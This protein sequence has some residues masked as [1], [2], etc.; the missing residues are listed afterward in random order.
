MLG[1]LIGDIAGTFYGL[2]PSD[3][4]KFPLFNQHC[5]LTDDSVMTYAIAEALL[6]GA[7]PGD[8]VRAI[9]KYKK[10]YS[11]EE[12]MVITDWGNGV[13]TRVS[14]CAWFADS[15]EEAEELAGR[16]ALST[17]K[18]PDDIRGAK[19][20][21]AAIYLARTGETKAEIRNL[22][23]SRYIYYLNCSLND[24]RPG[25]PMKVSDRDPVEEALIAFLESKSFEGAIRNA[26]SLGGRMDKI[27][28][29]TGSLAEAAYGI[30]A[31]LT[32]RAYDFIDDDLEK[33]IRRWAAFG[34]PLS[35]GAKMS[36]YAGF[37]SQKQF[38][39]KI[40][41]SLSDTKYKGDAYTGYIF[42][43]V[44]LEAIYGILG[45]IFD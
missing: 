9:E 3:L 5:Y 31:H 30:P 1:A 6:N 18:H 14:P 26:I 22:I 27:G 21:S 4:K 29:I 11:D 42:I 37:E 44:L 41:T 17:H 28:A 32:E 8:F 10:L 19:A 2:G 20:I 16:S 7:E 45:A 15:L 12:G 36:D 43:D 34:K 25:Y 35:F 33:I 23:S 40:G 24:I 13:A 39:K 38:V